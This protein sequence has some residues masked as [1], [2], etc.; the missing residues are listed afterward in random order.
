MVQKVN[1]PFDGIET[2]MMNSDYNILVM[3][4]TITEDAFKNSKDPIMQKAWV[5]RIEPNMDFYKEYLKAQGKDYTLM[6]KKLQHK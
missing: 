6:C 4:G 2:L 5:D 1:L 3:P